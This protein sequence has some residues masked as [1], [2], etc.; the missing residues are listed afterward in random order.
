MD[1]REVARKIDALFFGRRFGMDII[2]RTDEQIE[3]HR[4][5]GHSF[6]AKDILT[7]GKVL[8]DKSQRERETRA[9]LSG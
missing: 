8:Y 2:V 6:Y 9:T 3:D 5:R 7:D 4:R 1:C